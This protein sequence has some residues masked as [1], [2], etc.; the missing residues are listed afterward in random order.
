MTLFAVLRKQFQ[1]LSVAPEHLFTW[2]KQTDI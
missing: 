1:P 2:P